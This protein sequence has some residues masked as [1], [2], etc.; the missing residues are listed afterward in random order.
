[1][2]AS[3]ESS[4]SPA[5]ASSRVGAKH[6]LSGGCATTRAR[7]ARS[8]ATTLANSL[9]LTLLAAVC[10]SSAPRLVPLALILLADRCEAAGTVCDNSV[11]CSSGCP[12]FVYGTSLCDGTFTGTEVYLQGQGLSGTIPPQ[13]GDISQLTYL[14]LG[15]NSISGTIPSDT[16][17]LSQLTSL[18]LRYNSISGT[19][20]SET[21]KLSQLKD[22]SLDSNSISGTFPPETSKLSLLEHLGMRDTSISGTIPSAAVA[23]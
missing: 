7:L 5:P 22:I 12:T 8:P 18:S 17:K 23:D 10:S 6:A 4:A 16:G 20:P 1:M 15:S 21:S 3:G 14:D 9:V 11:P 19:I 13:L 2:Q